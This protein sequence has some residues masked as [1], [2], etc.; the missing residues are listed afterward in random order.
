[1]F[2]IAVVGTDYSE[3]L[4]GHSCTVAAVEKW[5]LVEAGHNYHDWKLI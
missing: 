4:L 5:L 3:F 1:M 2:F